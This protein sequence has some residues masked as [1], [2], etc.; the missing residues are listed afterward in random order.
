MTST[1]RER[2]TATISPCPASPCTASFGDL[3]VSLQRGGQ[4]V[5]DV[6]AGAWRALCE[7]A[8]PERAV[9]RP[10]LVS[11]YFS[12]FAPDAPVLLLSAWRNGDL[13]AILPLQESSI[14][15][16]PVRL[17]WLRTAGNLP[18]QRFDALY[19]EGEDPDAIASGFWRV[20]QRECP[21]HLFYGEMAMT[22]GV[23]DRMRERAASE[24]LLAREFGADAA[25][26]LEVPAPDMRME[27]VIAERGKSLRGS[28][29][30]GLRRLGERGTLR[31]V[32]VQETAEGKDLAEWLEMFCELE[33]RGWKGQSGSSIYSDSAACQLYRAFAHDERIR[34]YF[35]CA[36][37]MLDDEMI[38]ADLSLIV[39]TTRFAQ[40]LATNEE[41]RDCSPGH[42]LNL[43]LLLDCSRLGVTELDL[44]GKTEP[45]KMFWTDRTHPYSNVYIFPAGWQGRLLHAAIFSLALPGRDY[46]RGNGLALRLGRARRRFRA[47][48]SGGSALQAQE[49]GH[50]MRS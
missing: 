36:A 3:R 16:G 43:Y 12:A 18:F 47:R 20:I 50:G 48:R 31:F 26:F 40:K 19:G 15:A 9:L 6:H 28:L 14:G 13:V 21:R 29:R 34:P 10:E 42:L 5:I 39:G 37:L 33:H 2:A 11:A 41:L 4:E 17:R 46:L 24:G 22:G 45:Y 25:P 27:D 32:H 8:A 30:R 49:A 38:A 35:R 7:H 1:D 23:V 44:G